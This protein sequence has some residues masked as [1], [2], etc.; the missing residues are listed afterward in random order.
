M[1]MGDCQKAKEVWVLRKEPGRQQVYTLDGRFQNDQGKELLTMRD[2]VLGQ[3]KKY[4][5][6]LFK[7]K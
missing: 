5:T 6:S 3:M 2:E 4:T 1:A 7:D